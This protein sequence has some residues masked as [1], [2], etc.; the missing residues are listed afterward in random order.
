[1]TTPDDRTAF[2]QALLAWKA[3]DLDLLLSYFADDV[4]Y[5]VNVDGIQVPYA[6]SA[7]GKEDVRGRLE[8]VLATFQLQ[9]YTIEKIVHGADHSRALAHGIYRHRATGETLDIRLRFQAWLQD[10][11]LVRVHELHDAADIEAFEQFV[12]HLQTAAHAAG[13]A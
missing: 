5:L 4:L 11:L 8:L 2:L 6:M 3:Q 10:G 1:M 7:V 13:E 9:N 12:F